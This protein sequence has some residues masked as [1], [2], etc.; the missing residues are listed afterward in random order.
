MSMGGGGGD[1]IQIDDKFIGEA[2]NE[3]LAYLDQALRYSMPYSEYFTQ[4]AIDSQKEQFAIARQDAKQYWDIGQAQT[5]PYRE[6]GYQALDMVQDMLGMPRLSSGS[7]AM[8]HA[9]ENKAKA[10]AAR[11]DLQRQALQLTSQMNVSPEQAYQISQVAANGGNMSGFMRSMQQ[12]QLAN[13][14]LFKDQ[15]VTSTRNPNEG[16]MSS[17]TMDSMVD[18]IKGNGGLA[19]QPFKQG[20]YDNILAATSARFNPTPL[21][22]FMAGA[23]PSYQ[24]LASAENNMSSTA[25]TLAQLGTTGY[26]QLPVVSRDV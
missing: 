8:A 16:S 15:S 18:G 26:S 17:G 3:S 7:G 25:R 22:D 9:M 2:K 11:A 4:K 6:A 23:V 10:D 12:M 19:G 1:A 5:A 24:A 20:G 21:M 14:G 13:P